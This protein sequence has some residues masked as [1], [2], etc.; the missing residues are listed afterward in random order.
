MLKRGIVAL[1]DGTNPY[2]VPGKDGKKRQ[3]ISKRHAIGVDFMSGAP[4]LWD[5]P[6]SVHYPLFVGV[7]S[8][9]APV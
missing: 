3:G 5:V 8:L 2:Q 4:D 7:Q 1:G 9:H 6:L